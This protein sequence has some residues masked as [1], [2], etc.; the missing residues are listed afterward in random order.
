MSTTNRFDHSKVDPLHMGAR[1]RHMQAVFE[2]A[3]FTIEEE[4]R[5]GAT[6]AVCSGLNDAGWRNTTTEFFEYQV[7]KLIWDAIVSTYPEMTKIGMWPWKVEPDGVDLR[8]GVSA[9][10]RAWRTSR[11]L[12]MKEIDPSRAACHLTPVNERLVAQVKQRGSPVTIKK[13]ESE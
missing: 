6:E 3:G 9:V 1:R 5:R 2:A 7:D 8:L 12:P 4:E 11:R 13:E 10:Y